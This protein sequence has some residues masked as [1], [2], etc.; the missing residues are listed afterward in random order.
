MA[1]AKFMA[2]GYGRIARIIAGLLLIGVGLYIQNGWSIVVATVGLVP[3]F[4]G[5]FNV[6]V[7]APLFGG[8]FNGRNLAAST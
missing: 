4:A 2:S 5:V 7:F 8:P 1:F 6:C 3:V